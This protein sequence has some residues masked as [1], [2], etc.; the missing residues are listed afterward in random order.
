MPF[1]VAPSRAGPATGRHDD[2]AVRV[3][4]DAQV[5]ATAATGGACR[6]AGRPAA[7]RRPV[8]S[9]T[10]V[11]FD[12]PRRG[13]VTTPQQPA[14]TFAGLGAVE[15]RR[16]PVDDDVLDPGRVARRVRVGR[17]RRRRRRD[18]RRRGP[19]AHPR[20]RRRGRA[21]RAASAGTE[22][23][24]ATAVSSVSD[25]ALADV[26]RRGRA[27]VL[28]YVRGC[29]RPASRIGWPGRRPS[30]SVQTAIQGTAMIVST[31]ALAH[32]V[33]DDRDVE[34]VVDQGIEGELDGIDVELV[35][36][37]GERAAGPVRV[38]R[39][40][41]DHDAGPARVRGHVLPARDAAGHLRSDAGRGRRGSPSAATHASTPSAEQG[42][43]QDRREAGG[44]GRVRILVGGDVEAFGA[45]RLQAGDGLAG[46]A[47]DGARRALEVRDLQAGAR[48]RRTDR[49]DR[50]VERGEQVVALVAHVGRVQATAPGRRGDERL[51]LV[52]RSRASRAH[53][54]GPSRG[55]S[56]R[57]PSPP[58]PRR[59][60]RAAPRRSAGAASAPRTEPGPCRGRRGTRRSG[61]SGCSSTRSRYSP[62]VRQRATSPFG[63]RASVDVL[64][65]GVGDRRERVAAVPR[66][67]G[68]V[69]LVQ[70]A[71]QRRR[72]RGREPSEWPCGS[73]KP[74]RDDAA[75]GIQ[76]RLDVGVARPPR[77]RRPRGSGRRAG[78]RRRA[79]V[80]P[81]P[82]TS[83]P[84]RR[85]RSKAVN[86]RDDDTRASRDAWVGWHVIVN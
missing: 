40:E 75:A 69:A 4:H 86:A 33:D 61:P 39:R 3:D 77:G 78:R 23:S 46:P 71:G 56:P 66:Q 49:G 30:A 22:V 10:P 59:P 70:V 65:A 16:S 84:P 36:E 45:R 34:P 2:A 68:R 48:A 35:G 41:R 24:F 63:R 44:G 67:L 9:V 60:S 27:A 6:P 81:V 74:G 79:A 38:A 19:P 14:G 12:A 80:A 21:G 73:M 53:R 15:D 25:P 51:D 37:L 5:R 26:A 43:R 83:R 8:V 76:D 72:P 47:P 17:R 54:S 42:R 1:G 85:S 7:A 50:L 82:S 18:R 55:R 29:G 64:A 20:G 57:R 13:R 28:P 58:R 52:R 32:A 31:S 62:K 11:P